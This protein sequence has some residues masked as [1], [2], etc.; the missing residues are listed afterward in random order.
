MDEQRPAPRPATWP[1]VGYWVRA[2]LAAAATLLAVQALVRVA[3]VVVIVLVAA[4]LAVGLDP[5]ARALERRGLRRGLAIALIVIVALGGVVGFLALV[6]PPLVGQV[7]G[8]ANDIPGY[9]ERLASRGDLLGRFVRENDVA[10]ALRDWLAQLPSTI[11]GSFGA[12]VGFTGRVTGAVFSIVTVF[13]L[14]VYFLAALPRARRVAPA[15]LDGPYRDRGRRVLDE[16]IAKI[17]GYVIG[18]L[19]TSLICAIA[20]G[21]AL[22]I[23]GV[24]FTVPLAVWAG[25][26]DLIPAV[27]AYLGAAPAIIVAFF[28]SP[29]DGLIVLLYFLIY[30]QIENY[31]IVPRVM[32]GAVDLS[33]AAVVISTLV[34]GVLAGFAGAI[35]ALPIAATIKVVVSDVWLADRLA[36]VERPDRR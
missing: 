10:A 18:N 7:A 32:R 15:L 35:L 5:A 16:A 31:L 13:I 30:Q 27:G 1:T 8:L 22:G 34:G 25:L 29:T 17:G 9:V 26:A 24:P 28:A 36:S 6:V 2:T 12:I 14:A 33:P 20:A 4:V 19:T 11:S 23:I 21:V 3:N